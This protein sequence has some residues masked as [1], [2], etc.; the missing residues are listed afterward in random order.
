MRSF[1]LTAR[2]IGYTP[3]PITWVYAQMGLKTGMVSGIMGG[4][5][6]GYLGL[7]AIRYFLP[8][9]DHFEY[10]FIYMNLELWT[11]LPANTQEVIVKAAEEM[12]AERYLHAEHDESRSIAEL[13]KHGIEVLEIQ[14]AQ[15]AK[16]R[17]KIQ[18]TVWP[19]LREDIG[20]VFD[21]VVRFTESVR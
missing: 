10:W 17:Q 16:M 5:A 9:K 20:P 3:Y 12:E 1:Q 14:N 7:P 4:G 6:E 18:L 8:V 2:Q 19:V 13:Q 15:Y 11:S 21:D